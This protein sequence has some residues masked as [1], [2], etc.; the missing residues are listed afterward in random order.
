MLYHQTN[1]NFLNY[2]RDFLTDRCNLSEYESKLLVLDPELGTKL[3][4]EKVNFISRVND[5]SKDIDDFFINK[6][7][8]SYEMEGFNDVLNEFANEFDHRKNNI[9]DYLKEINHPSYYDL[10]HLKSDKKYINCQKCNAKYSIPYSNKKLKIKCKRCNFV[11][12]WIPCDI[13]DLENLYVDLENDKCIVDINEDIVTDYDKKGNYILE[14]QDKTEEIGS[15]IRFELICI[16]NI[17]TNKCYAW[18]GLDK[19]WGDYDG[20]V[21][22]SDLFVGKFNFYITEN[23]I[24]RLKNKVVEKKLLY[25]IDTFTANVYCYNDESGK[26]KYQTDK[27]SE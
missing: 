18:H 6:K 27:L 11:M 4:S 22:G 5:T 12:Y 17:K 2:C 8:D 10:E 26:W 21:K 1:I 7:Y 13:F 15:S 9:L 25:A 19:A 16:K 14:I 3:D 23:N 24:V 20:E